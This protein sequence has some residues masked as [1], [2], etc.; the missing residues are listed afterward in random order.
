MAGFTRRSGKRDVKQFDSAA[1]T[2][3]PIAVDDVVQFDEN[4]EVI[5]GVTS[6]EILGLA[7]EASSATTDR[8]LVDV[9]KPGDEVN[10]LIETGTMVAA[11]VGEEADL[12]SA[13]G[14]TLTE[15]NNDFLITG[16]DGV[17]T[18]ACWGVLKNLAT[19]A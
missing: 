2:G 13:D 19:G 18:T 15:S 10:A 8:I 7:L 1:S 3:A 11:E 16:W 6:A 9:L 5:A 12:N 17:T 4:G 14:L